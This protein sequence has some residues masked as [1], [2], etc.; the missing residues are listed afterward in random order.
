[1]S[2]PEHH[3][4]TPEESPEHLREAASERSK[5]LR[6]R[7]EN[8]LE[9]K[10]S[11]QREVEAERAHIEALFSK[12]EGAEK[13]KHGANAELAKKHV[14][15]KQRESSYKQTM[16]RIRSDMPPAQRIFSR[17]IH[18]P[19]I[20][21][22]SDIAGSTIARP[23]AILAG[24]FGAFVFVAVIYILASTMG[25]RLSGFETIGAFII[26]WIIGA[27]YDLIK[28]MVTGKPR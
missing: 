21:K 15:K 11:Q 3:T 9:N 19:A 25:F 4:G 17:F 12:K 26:G 8:K 13:K 18:N 22:T 2:N 20:E 6:E 7:L 24:G 28:T 23:N 27:S 16:K 1:M 14:T 10:E 5:E